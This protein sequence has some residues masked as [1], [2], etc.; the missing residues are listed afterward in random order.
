MSEA[1]AAR[2]A[3]VIYELVRAHAAKAPPPRG[4]PYLGL[5]HASGTGLHLLDALATRGIFRK[6]ELVLDLGAGLGA[7]ARWLA[8]RLGCEVVGTTADTSEATAAA[9]LTRRAGLG[10]Q[11]RFVSA[12]AAL[13]FLPGRFTH[14]WVLEALPTFAA[15]DAVLAEAFQALRR[16]GT[17]A[18]QDLVVERRGP[19]FPPG[20]DPATTDER[21][22]QIERAGFVEL[23]VRDRSSEAGETSAQA[24]ALRGRLLRRLRDEPA[25]GA[26]VAVRDTLAARI[27]DGTLRVV[28][29]LARRP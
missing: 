1:P 10:T 3:A 23:E 24:L 8:A 16:G 11:V 29:L 22:A 14:V 2:L 20:F 12:S 4:L 18:V 25:L 27:A 9:Y 13:P 26:L 17:L 21:V 5:E 15:A 6:Y 19:T 28:Q 7:S